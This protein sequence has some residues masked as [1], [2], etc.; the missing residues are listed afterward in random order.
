MRVFGRE[1]HVEVKKRDAWL[2]E[3]L[4]WPKDP[5][6]PEDKVKYCRIVRTRKRNGWQ[7]CLQLV[8]KGVPPVKH[9]Y[10]PKSECM[11]IDPSTKSITF[12]TAD[13]RIEKVDITGGA[14]QDWKALARINRAMD[15]S[16]RATNPD[17]YNEDGT[18]KPGPKRWVCSNNYLRLSDQRAEERRHIA[19]VR[20]NAH[21]R[22]QNT[23]LSIAGTIRV[24]E[25]SYKAFQ[26]GRYGKSIGSGAPA[27]FISGLTR[28]AESAGC[29]V[30]MVNP[31][32]LKPSQHDI[33]T[34]EF[35]KRELSDRRVQLGNTDLWM[36]RD[37]AAVVNLL[38]ADIEKETYDPS[39]LHGALEAWKHVWLDAGVLVEQARN[40][41]SERELG[42]FRR[43]GLPA[44]SVDELRR[45]MIHDHGCRP[46]GEA[47]ADAARK[48]PGQNGSKP[49]HFSDRVA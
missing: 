15:R 40:G 3:A 8:L 35:V 29:E 48:S 5:A 25:N 30:V 9:V 49:R 33:L 36:D 46:C 26:R 18:V 4:S 37:A 21:G 24:E 10:A 17:N 7:Y 42:R 23:V 1:L 45:K 14:Q 32:K 31:R 47:K 20:K 12:G 44:L 43:Q 27:A 41:L 6:H 13:G 28:K 34:G 22:L 11:A 38:Y 39:R 16:R 19:A 2:R